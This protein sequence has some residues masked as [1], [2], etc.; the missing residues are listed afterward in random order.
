MEDG[1]V[2]ADQDSHHRKERVAGKTD[3]AVA[4]LIGSLDLY[5]VV[6]VGPRPGVKSGFSFREMHV[7]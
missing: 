1:P 3:L 6:A 4:V 2:L 7:K 5:F